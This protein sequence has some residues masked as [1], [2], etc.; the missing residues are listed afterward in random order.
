MRA[1]FRF[2]ERLRIV[3]YE[4]REEPLKLL[5]LL[6][7]G[8]VE[9]ILIGGV[10]ARMHGASI[11]T[12]DLDVALSMDPENLVKVS[13]VLQKANARFR[14]KESPTY[15]TEDKARGSEWKNLYFDT[16]LGVLDCLGE[17]QG[18]GDYNAC[19]EGSCEVV[20]GNF[21]IRVLNLETL[22][23]AKEAVGRPKDLR[24]VDELKVAGGI[25]SKG[26]NDDSAE[27]KMER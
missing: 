23:R 15:F 7:V 10:A 5:E 26:S 19:L 13:R 4:M 17:V 21:T 27:G 8:R 22:I 14:H 3:R 9:F 25:G 6:S 12:D 18:V 24:T 11:Q 16:E 2:N 20:L 1:R